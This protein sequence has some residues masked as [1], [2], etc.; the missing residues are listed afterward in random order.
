[1]RTVAV[2][3]IKMKFHLK[4]FLRSWIELQ[5]RPTTFTGPLG[6]FCEND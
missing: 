2:Q 3:F 4:I 5:K 6:K 1:M